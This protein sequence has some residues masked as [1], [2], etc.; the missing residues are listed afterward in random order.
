M[1]EPTTTTSTAPARAPLPDA[2]WRLPLRTRQLIAVAIL[3]VVVVLIFGLIWWLTGDSGS[4][5][6]PQE[7]GP[8]EATEFLASL[9]PE[10]VAT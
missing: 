8:D 5:D 7:L 6:T 1:S 4:S 3:V 2:W 10:R 9:P